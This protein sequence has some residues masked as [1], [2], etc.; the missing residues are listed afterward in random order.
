MHLDEK[1]PAG[2]Y[3]LEARGEGKTARDLVL[4]T[5]ASMVLKTSGKQALVYVCNALAGSPL[6]GAEVKL[7]QRYHDGK[8]WQWQEDSKAANQDGIAVFDLVDT[9]NNTQLFVSSRVGDRQTFSTGS[10]YNYGRGNREE[11]WRIYALTDRP[12]YRPNETA[13]WK[14]IA[15]KYNGSVYATPANEVVE[16]EIN[17][18]HG[19][20]VKADKVTLNAFGS[21]WGSLELT[22]SM[23][24]GEYHVTFWNE[25]RKRQIGSATLFRLE[26]YK[27]PE[28]KVSVQTP[29]ENGRKKAFR[30]GEKV[31]VNVQADYYFGGPVANA[32]VELIVTQNPFYHYWHQP[33]EYPWFYDNSAAEYQRS[34]SWGRGQDQIIKRET[35]KTDAAGKASLTFDTPRDPNQEF[36]YR[37]E[38]RVTDASRR[39]I[40]GNGVVRV[41]RQ[42]Y[43]VYPQA[44]HNLY[45]PQGQG[46]RRVQGPR[47][48]RPAGVGGGNRQ[49]HPRLLV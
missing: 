15:R 10:S 4:V 39:E 48:E 21:A 20:K 11:P 14:F 49:S 9:P 40:T 7:W 44:A 27:L 17:D 3:I 38:A 8:R 19:A 2:A 25:G 18:P 1:L 30:L 5:D 16:F 29:E 22:D 24:L 12:A 6:A 43:Y 32:N 26:E 47:R 13:Q 33:R 42:R 36:E 45:A 41:T 37:I 46:K 31:E 34:R 28:F 23:P 35:L